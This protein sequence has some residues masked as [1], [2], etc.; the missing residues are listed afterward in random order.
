[1]KRAFK[2]K[3]KPFFVIFKGLSFAVN[4]LRP[5]CASEFSEFGSFRIQIIHTQLS[6]FYLCSW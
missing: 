3:W 5:E 2:V 4:C 1:M 6:F